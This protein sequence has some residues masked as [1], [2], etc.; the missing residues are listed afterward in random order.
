MRPMRRSRRFLKQ[1]TDINRIVY[2]KDYQMV[3]ESA[4]GDG[5]HLLQY[6]GIYRT[7]KDAALFKQ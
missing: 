4:G 3:V 1:K 6:S 7:A 2:E 5:Y